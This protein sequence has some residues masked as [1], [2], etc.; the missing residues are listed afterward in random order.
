MQSFLRHNRRCEFHYSP[1]DTDQVVSAAVLAVGIWV[2]ADK[3]SFIKLTLNVTHL[4]NT[5]DGENS[6]ELLKVSSQY[7]SPS[8]TF[9]FCS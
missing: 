6:D 3:T 5:T 7:L 4:T 2:A 8:Q 1:H 9:Y